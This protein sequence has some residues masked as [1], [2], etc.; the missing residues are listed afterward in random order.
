MAAKT[1]HVFEVES[2]V[3]RQCPVCSNMPRGNIG[4]HDFEE[5]V[6]HLV[7]QH[8]Y[9]ILHVGQKTT[10]DDHGNPWQTTVAILGK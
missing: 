2:S 1:K 9:T 4:G 8:G 10:R 6:N 7:Q 3:W 5:Q